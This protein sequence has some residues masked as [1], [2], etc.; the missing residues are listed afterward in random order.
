MSSSLELFKQGTWHSFGILRSAKT[1]L[2]PGRSI[3]FSV[4]SSSPPGLVDCRVRG[5]E[6]GLKGTSE[7]MPQEFSAILLGYEYW[8]SGRTIGPV[9]KLANLSKQERVSYLL[10][11]LVE[12]QRLGWVAATAIQWYAQ[13]LATGDSA[14][15]S[16]H[17]QED[18][19]SGVITSEMFA[20]LQPV[21]E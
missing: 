1:V 11:R 13:N 21:S 17:A 12:F 6:R 2:T 14:A 5:G 15:I 18:L 16:K 10:D 3:S 20:L 4:E 8:P 9:D 7:E 19:T